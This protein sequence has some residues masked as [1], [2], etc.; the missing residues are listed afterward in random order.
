VS[1]N[2]ATLRVDILRQALATASC[3]TER[4]P[5]VPILG[6]L[7]ISAEAGVLTAIGTNMEE[8]VTAD[9]PCR[10]TLRP[11]TISAHR[12][13][14]ILESLPGDADVTLRHDDDTGLATIT[15]AGMTAHLQS[16]PAKDFPEPRTQKAIAQ[17]QIT[18]GTFRDLF[19]RAEHAISQEET[20]YYLNGVF[21]HVWDD[22]E[23]PTLRTAATDGHRLITL[24]APMP[25]GDTPLPMIVHKDAVRQLL[26]LLAD[27]HDDATLIIKQGELSLHVQRPCWS[28]D[29]KAIDGTF[30]DFQRV[31]PKQAGRSLL[32][33]HDPAAFATLI[34]QARAIGR[35]ATLP[36]L[37]RAAE[38]H[39]FT[40][41]ARSSEEGEAT[42]HVPP[43]VAQWLPGA[44]VQIA[45]QAR[46]LA[47]L[48][49]ALP[50]RFTMHVIDGAAPP[51]VTSRGATAC[52]MPMMLASIDLPMRAD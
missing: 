45:F 8:R 36:V 30:P 18:A 17:W 6:H 23:S 1:D 46:Y 37:F 13:N 50:E 27:T 11:F 4:H 5:S 21:L 25:E 34:Q 28:H 10:G 47:D 38:G 15:S 14:A 24:S 20:R 52:L 43:E 16:R 3:A 33:V 29:S 48:C 31:M 12:A 39:P 35:E 7:L 44:D 42:V 26:K 40:I 2:T 51:R 22:V 32:D 9:C 49:R 19:A 41:S